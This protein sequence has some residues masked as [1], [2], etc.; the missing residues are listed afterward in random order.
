[1]PSSISW[2][3]LSNK[4]RRK[5]MEVVRLFQEQDT[6]DEIGIAAIRDSLAETLFPGTGTLQTR[7]R[8]FLIIPWLLRGFEDRKVKSNRI[9]ERLRREEVRIIHTLIQI[10]EGGV[11]GQISRE[12]L[13]RFPS[14]IYWNGLR[15]WGILKFPGSP[16]D[17][18][19]SL[20]SY[21]QSQRAFGRLEGE[22]QQIEGVFSN[23]D[24]NLPEAPKDFPAGLDLNLTRKESLYLKDKLQLHCADS[25][26]G[27]FVRLG[28]P[29][30]EISFAWQ[31]PAYRDLPK[32][33]QEKVHHAQNFSEIIHGA[34]LLYNYLLAEKA[35]MADRVDDFAHRLGEWQKVIDGR[36]QFLSQWDLD[37]FWRLVE[38][39]KPLPP[40]LKQFVSAWVGI[41]RGLSQKSNIFD[42]D[43]PR[44]LVR[45]REFQLKGGRSRFENPR[46]LE[47]WGGS[48]GA[49]QL[50]YRWGGAKRI[51]NDIV[52]GLEREG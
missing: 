43:E 4:D 22:E 41:V 32:A 18:F 19:Q 49:G 45:D 36:R 47:V 16:W 10:G 31:H 6:R 37:Q 52:T 5:M 30:G 25:L 13:N 44:R 26:L 48:S 15:R 23:W 11:I 12:N 50:D 7:A 2:L 24:P 8:Y 35:Q 39:L 21:Y 27:Y 3:D 51:I 9:A 46:R 38:G 42:L 34:A 1:M 17:Y 28:K 20:D 29:I 14:S 33:L 40:R